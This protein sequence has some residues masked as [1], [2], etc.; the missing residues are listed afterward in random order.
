MSQSKEVSQKEASKKVQR[1]WFRRW[2][3]NAAEEVYNSNGITINGDKP[4]KI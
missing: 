1:N 4:G 2:M 3:Y